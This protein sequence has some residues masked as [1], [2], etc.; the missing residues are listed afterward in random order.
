MKLVIIYRQKSFQTHC[1][2]LLI[3]SVS[4]CCRLDPKEEETVIGE[5]AQQVNKLPSSS[6]LSGAESWGQ[7]P[8]QPIP[9]RGVAEPLQRGAA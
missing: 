9:P 1:G 4:V 6:A 5:M 8:K 3:S 2:S 7:Q